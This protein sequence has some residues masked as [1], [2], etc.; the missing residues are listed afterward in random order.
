MVGVAL[1]WL[2]ALS[3]SVD[4]LM[5]AVK[6]NEDMRVAE[7]RSTLL[8]VKKEI[9]AYMLATQGS[10]SE[11]EEMCLEV[12]FDHEMKA[13][14]DS[15]DLFRAQGFLAMIYHLADRYPEAEYVTRH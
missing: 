6:D 5:R 3:G 4:L 14:E 9:L 12:I 1:D 7:Y 15:G 11:A 2:E 10:Y 8:E 13:G